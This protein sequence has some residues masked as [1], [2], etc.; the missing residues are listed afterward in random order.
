MNLLLSEQIK[1]K[2]KEKFVRWKQHKQLTSPAAM[3]A[4]AAAGY[5]FTLQA[6]LRLNDCTNV[7]DNELR[8]L[9]AQ[10]QL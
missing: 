7:I 1:V 8:M 2:Q 6:K 5:V 10:H 3:L 9:N 4:T